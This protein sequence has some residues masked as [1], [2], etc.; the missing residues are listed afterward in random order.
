MSKYFWFMSYYFIFTYYL[1]KME[2]FN[3]NTLF[4][5][6]ESIKGFILLYLIGYILNGFENFLNPMDWSHWFIR[7]FFFQL[8]LVGLL[9]FI[10]G[11]IGFEVK[12]KKFE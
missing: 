1:N 12:K 9:C 5:I 8:P 11:L 10:F 7:L 3:T 2:K 6:L 4:L